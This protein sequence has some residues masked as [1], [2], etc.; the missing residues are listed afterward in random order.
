MNRY[1][2]ATAN[3]GRMTFV[4]PYVDQFGGGYVVTVCRSLS[5]DERCSLINS[6]SSKALQ[7]I[8]RKSIGFSD[9][10]NSIVGV[11]GVDVTVNYMFVLLERFFPDCAVH[12][13]DSGFR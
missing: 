11:I 2:A 12:N 10:Q 1:K 6:C 9:P 13:T 3:A 8:Y 4:G 5:T 7:Y